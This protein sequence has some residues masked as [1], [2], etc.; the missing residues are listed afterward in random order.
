MPLTRYGRKK[1]TYIIDKDSLVLATTLPKEKAIL[2]VD[3]RGKYK[4]DFIDD[5]WQGPFMRA[6]D[7]AFATGDNVVT[8]RLK[9]QLFIAKMVQISTKRVKMYTWNIEGVRDIEEVIKLIE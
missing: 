2:G 3:Y 4:V 6:L 5:A 1:H 9:G 7:R 8:Y